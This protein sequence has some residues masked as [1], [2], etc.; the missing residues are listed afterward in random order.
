[1]ICSL[2]EW[3]TD[4]WEKDC[5]LSQRICVLCPSTRKWFHKKAWFKKLTVQNLFP[6]HTFSLQPC[7]PSTTTTCD[8]CEKIKI[9][10]HWKGKWLSNNISQKDTVLL[11]QT[12]ETIA[13]TL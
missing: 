6:P 1:M 4:E 3:R 12:P 2:V 5:V 7:S 11:Q 8:P 13:V 9:V 10:G